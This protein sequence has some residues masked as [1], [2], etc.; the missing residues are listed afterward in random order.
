[1]IINKNQKVKNEIKKIIVNLIFSLKSLLYYIS[2]KKLNI[3]RIHI[4]SIL[5]T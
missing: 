1:M 2:I 4:F 5:S 3:S